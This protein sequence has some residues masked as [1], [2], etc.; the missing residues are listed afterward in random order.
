VG[1]QAV[2][3]FASD[4]VA[5]LPSELRIPTAVVQKGTPCLSHLL[6][7]F[8]RGPPGTRSSRGPPVA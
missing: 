2:G 3:R 1:S 7:H 6:T 5:I 4:S 8:R